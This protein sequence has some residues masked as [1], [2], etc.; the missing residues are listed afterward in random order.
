MLVVAFG[1]QVYDLSHSVFKLGLIG[2]AQFLPQLCLTLVVGPIADRLDRRRI[3]QTCQLL[4]FLLGLLLALACLSQRQSLTLIFSCAALVGSARAF[5]SPSMQSLL[6]TL[7]STAQLPKSL[8][9]GAA[10]RQSAVIAGP[11]LGGL[12]YAL[13][14]P[15]V[16]GACAIAYL[17]AALWLA[18]LPQVQTQRQA[19]PISLQS[20]FAGVAFIRKKPVILG[21]ISLDLFSV[22]LGG[23]TALLPVY[24]R[25]ILHAGAW[26]L[27]LLRSAPA[28][29]ALSMS[30]WL[31]RH[32]LERHVGRSMGLAVGVFGLA[33]MVFGLSHWFALSLV[34][35]AALGASDMI[36]VVV[37]SSLVQLET[38]D[39]MRGRVSAVNFIFIGTSNQLGEFESGLTA[40]WLG[41]MPA[42]VMGGVG[43][44]L[45]VVLWRRW[46]PEL[47]QRDRLAPADKV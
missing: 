33:T 35:L 11:A 8:A 40:A 12:V 5:E 1:W 20:V 45:V 42:V 17:L 21:A 43:T 32:P 31:A 19:E 2:L 39:A 37:R 27:G 7:V 41:A 3:A 36:S 28:I 4:Q 38:P 29:G 25:D 24:A 47:F 9:W 18:R 26:G 22:L 16:Y 14:A 34:A 44:L 6:P 15:W 46:F 10:A 30:L 23:A 13:G